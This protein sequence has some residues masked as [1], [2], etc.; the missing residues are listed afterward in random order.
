M[1]VNLFILALKPPEPPDDDFLILSSSKENT[2]IVPYLQGSC[3]LVAN[4]EQS[5]SSK[6]LDSWFDDILDDG[7]AVGESGL[8]MSPPTC[9]TPCHVAPELSPARDVFL[10][11]FPTYQIVCGEDNWPSS[12]PE[13]GW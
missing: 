7:F 4:K 6:S 2:A 3:M 13:K 10:K 8:S 1:N 9:P 12:D 11:K 5:F